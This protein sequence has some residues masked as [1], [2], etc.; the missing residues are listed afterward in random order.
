MSLETVVLAVDG[1]QTNADADLAKAAADIAGPAEATVV[2][3]R[4]HTKD[5]YETIRG[6][7]NADPDSEVTPETVAARRT[8]VRE[9]ADTLT[10]A[11]LDLDVQVRS[12][13]SDGDTDQS[14]RLVDIAEETDADLLLV[15]GHDRTPIGKAVFGSTAQEVMLD[16]PCPVTFVR[17]A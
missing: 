8:D 2:L 5:E 11:D 10:E 17:A 13:L 15:G 14:E 6:L 4:I 12:R 3:A 9:L 1:T 7:L 16:A